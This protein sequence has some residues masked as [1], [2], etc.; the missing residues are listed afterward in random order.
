MIFDAN[1]DQ[2]FVKLN[3]IVAWFLSNNNFTQLP[4]I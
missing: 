3:D 1:I 4:Y 2:S